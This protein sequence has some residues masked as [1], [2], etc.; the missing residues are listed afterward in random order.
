MRYL[1]LST[2]SLLALACS[3]DARAP[4][5]DAGAN[6]AASDDGF[7]I[8]SRPPFQPTSGAPAPPPA[9]STDIPSDFVD[10]ELGG[11]KLGAALD[12]ESSTTRLNETRADPAAC[13]VMI[14]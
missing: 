3:S 2:L 10:T 11:Y 6:D 5:S 14:G 4:A 1:W 7:P 12:S 9:V 8:D 13:S